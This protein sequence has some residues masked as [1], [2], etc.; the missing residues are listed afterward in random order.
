MR[1]LFAVLIM[2]SI[3]ASGLLG[4]T[5]A[6]AA[7]EPATQAPRQAEPETLFSPQQLDNLVASVAL[8][9]DPLLAQVVVAAT[10]PEQVDEAARFLRAGANPEAID[11]QPWDVSV[12]AVARYPTVLYMMADNLDWTT[13]LGQAYVYQSTEVM[14]AVQRLRARARS[15]GHLVST[16][17]M[18][19]VEKK[20]YIALWPVYPRTLY[21][22]A[23]DP[24][25]VFYP[26]PYYWAGPAISF[27]IG[28]AVGS[29]LIYD[30]D[31]HHHHVYYHGWAHHRGGWVHRYRPHV[32][33]GR[34]YVHKGHPHVRGNR[35]VLHRRVNY[36]ALK[37]YNSVHRRVHYDD[38]HR[39]RA[40][41]DRHDVRRE[42]GVIVHRHNV[43][44]KVIHRNF[45]TSDPRIDTN[46]G[47]LSERR[48]SRARPR[49]DVRPVPKQRQPGVR[50]EVRPTPE[51]RQP[52]PQ[53]EVR[54]A[55]QRGQTMPRVVRPP[56]RQPSR[57]IQRR[58][59]SVFRRSR[60]GIAPRT[61]RQRGQ[62]S[63]RQVQRSRPTTRSR[64]A[65]RAPVQRRRM[66][67][68]R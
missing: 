17:Q 46:R 22:P 40:R 54:P 57:Q 66:P 68:R 36:H 38:V 32:R 2:F 67:S 20:E 51:R 34:A 63:R 12:K 23:Y 35:R 48:I 61:A 62:V 55:P 8:Y 7:D 18:E 25:L 53:R 42:R 58:G 45:D 49:R 5:A 44:N 39:R 13:S 29:W 27:G 15:A 10:F 64:P 3:V 37:R 28:F 30:F 41:V 4:G 50:H 65:R 16:P 33:H 24:A 52:R 11:D 9:P 26:Y 56:S 19:V 59:D 21:V 47:R 1:T 14:A 31:W 43:R 60:S 6:R